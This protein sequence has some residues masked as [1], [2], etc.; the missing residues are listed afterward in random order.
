MSYEEWLTHFDTWK[1]N[2]PDYLCMNINTLTSSRPKAEKI[3]TQAL[4]AEISKDLMREIERKLPHL[5][6]RQVQSDLPKAIKNITFKL[7]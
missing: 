2:N 1:R 6:S 5:V 4:K 3:D 7:K